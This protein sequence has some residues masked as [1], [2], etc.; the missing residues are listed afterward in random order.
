M[1][2]VGWSD[3]RIAIFLSTMRFFAI[4]LPEEPPEGETL[5]DQGKRIWSD[6]LQDREIG[7]E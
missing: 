6:S 3:G 1:V 2:V 4:L 7:Q 5:N